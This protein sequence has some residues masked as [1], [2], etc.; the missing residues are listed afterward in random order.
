MGWLATSIM[1]ARGVAQGRTGTTHTLSEAQQGKYRHTIGP[2][3]EPVL[4]V[5]PGDRIVVETLDAF[6]GVI[7]SEADRPSAKLEMPFVNPQN[8]PIVIDGANKGDVLA[9]HV[10]AI[11]PRGP[12]P[13]GTTCLI[14]EFG[15]LTGTNLTALLNDPLPEIVRKVEVDEQH[16]HWSER[17]KL[18]Y[19]PFIGTIGVAPEIDS[20]TSLTPSSHGGNM[21]LPDVAPGNVLYLPVRAAGAHLYLGDC[22]A[23]QGDGEICGVAIEMASTTT[24]RV[25]LIKDWPIAWPRLETADAIMCIGSVR[26]L[27]DAVRIAYRD[28]VRWMA[29]DYG[30]DR[31][32]A[33]LLLTQCGKVRLGNVVDPNYTVGAGINK[34][35]LGS[36]S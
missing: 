14:P 16:V 2:Y 6:G 1:H 7:R 10:E 25:D 8:G 15:G 12:Q 5:A 33:Y 20:I 30:F 13:R 22:H 3:A 19:R 27:E 24:I 29:A 36:I 26:P 32:D 4:S 21:D 35:Y 31:W 34:A 9:V 23:T 18:P 17:V 11:A 28:L